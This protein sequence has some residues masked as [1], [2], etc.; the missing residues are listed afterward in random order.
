MN[1]RT[2]N[3]SA[4]PR[5][6]EATICR[7]LRL[8]VKRLA[9]VRYVEFMPTPH[10]NPVNAESPYAIVRESEPDGLGGIANV[11]TVFL[12][13]AECPIGCSMCDLWRNTLTT[14]TPAGAI[15]TQI[16]QAIR[17][18][19]KSDWIKL[20]N[21]GNFFDPR[22][23][24]PSDYASIA[25]QTQAFQKIIVENHPRFGRDRMKTFRDLISGRLEVAVGLET[26][27][28]RWLDRIGKRMTRDDFDGYA[29]WLRSENVDLRVFLIVG[30]PGITAAES[31]RWAS[32]SVRHAIAVGARHV[33][34]IPARAGHGWNGQADLLPII[35][36]DQMEELLMASIA[37]AD[38]AACVTV[39]LWDMD[40]TDACYRRMHRSNL[41]QMVMPCAT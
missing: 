24:P 8:G 13:A 31:I 26:V 36:P 32:L 9:S 3:C 34:L 27:Q 20:Y 15:G 25:Q 37:G 12:T 30:V 41:S 40:E 39:D 1:H 29:K 35:K 10:R 17:G 16:D 4:S 11:L 6:V 33:S 5:R 19:E 22:S 38:G 23:I 21:S 14:P 2:A 28:P 18:S 7:R